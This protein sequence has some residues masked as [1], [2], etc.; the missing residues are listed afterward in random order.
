MTGEGPVAPP[1]RSDADRPVP[2]PGVE[3]GLDDQPQRPEPKQPDG[4]RPAPTELALYL[5][6]ETAVDGGQAVGEWVHS[7]SP[8][9]IRHRNRAKLAMQGAKGPWNCTGRGPMRSDITVVQED[10]RQRGPV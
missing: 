5:L 10:A 2:Q 1:G 4:V 6:V 8:K 9:S 7:L 3:P